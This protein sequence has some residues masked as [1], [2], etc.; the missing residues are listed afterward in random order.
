MHS[1]LQGVFERATAEERTLYQEHDDYHPSE[2]G[3][4]LIGEE[5]GRLVGEL[6]KGETETKVFPKRKARL[7]RT[8]S[9]LQ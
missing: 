7:E 3:H 4:R 5:I 8:L 9:E 2:C 6:I 1:P